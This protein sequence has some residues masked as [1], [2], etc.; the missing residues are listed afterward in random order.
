M[1]ANSSILLTHLI[2][3]VDLEATCCDDDSFPRSE[4]EIIEFGCT[5]VDPQDDYKVVATYNTFVRP[6]VHPTLTDFCKNLTTINQSDVDGADTWI[7]VSRD[8]ES[9]FDDLEAHEQ[10]PIAW[11]SWGDYDRNQISK[12]CRRWYIASEPMPELHFNLKRLD[13]AW[14]NTTKEHGL[15]GTIQRLGLTFPGTLHRASDDAAAVA[16]VLKAIGPGLIRSKL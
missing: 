11:T 12:E 13:A 15:R 8:I 7:D 5:V 10:R 14:R 4:M 3:C 9:F 6:V 16:M 2:A 1:T